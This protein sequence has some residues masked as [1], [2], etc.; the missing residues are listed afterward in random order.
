MLPKSL[1]LFPTPEAVKPIPITE[2]DNSHH[3]T[4]THLTKID[5]WHEK[6]EWW[7]LV[8]PQTPSWIVTVGI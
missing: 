6:T 8:P 7:N 1:T 4:L 3:L 2:E 5:L